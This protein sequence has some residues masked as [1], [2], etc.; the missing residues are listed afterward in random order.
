[1][2]AVIIALPRRV[3]T[4]MIVTAKMTYMMPETR[5]LLVQLKV[6]LRLRTKVRTCPTIEPIKKPIK[7]EVVGYPNTSLSAPRSKP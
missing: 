6:F 3:C 4:K 1:M 5:T 7:S 2:Q